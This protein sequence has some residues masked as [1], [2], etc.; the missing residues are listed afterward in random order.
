MKI[1]KAALIMLTVFAFVTI[2][3][4]SVGA[5]SWDQKTTFT[6]HQPVEIPGGVLAPGTYTFQLDRG[7]SARNIVRIYN[8]DGMKLVTTLMTV[9]DESRVATDAATLEF[10]P[11]PVGSPRALRAFFYY[12]EKI[13]RE[14]LYPNAQAARLEALGAGNVPTQGS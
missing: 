9:N 6:F 4:K 14:F 1:F 13:G 3:A 10:H 8:D 7:Y 5:D 2:M 12:G 11:G